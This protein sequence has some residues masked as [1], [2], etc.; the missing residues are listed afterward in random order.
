M[1]AALCV[2][3]LYLNGIWP[4]FEVVNGHQK[5]KCYNEI[6]LRD[7]NLSTILGSRE[8]IIEEDQ[9]KEKE[10]LQ[11]DFCI[12]PPMILNLKLDTIICFIHR[13]Y[14]PDETPLTF[15]NPAECTTSGMARGLSKVCG[16]PYV[17]THLNWDTYS[18]VGY[19]MRFSFT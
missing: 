8:H 7:Q 15:Q 17:V 6:R 9:F 2:A 1:S 18:W 16:P 12:S 11:F 4:G 5:D 3:H 10:N 14:W 13:N 19:M